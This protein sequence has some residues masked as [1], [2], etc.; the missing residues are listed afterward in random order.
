MTLLTLLRLRWRRWWRDGKTQLLLRLLWVSLLGAFVGGFVGWVG[1]VFPETLAQSGVQEAPTRVLSEHLLSVFAGLL[2][3]R[4]VLQRFVGFGWRPFLALPVERGFLCAMHLAAAGSLL[5]L[6]SLV[7]IAGLLASTIA[8]AT[9]AVGTAFWGVGTVLLVGATQFAHVILRVAWARRDWAV[10]LGAGGAAVGLIGADRAGVAVVRT[11]SAWLFGGLLD[12]G[13][14]PLLVIGAATGVLALRSTAALRRYTRSLT[15]GTGTTPARRWFHLDAWSWTH[16]SRLLLLQCIV[17]LRYRRGREL[18]LAGGALLVSGLGFL[19]VVDPGMLHT[20]AGAALLAT[21]AFFL[22]G[23]LPFG[24]GRFS[25]TWHSIHFDA[26]LARTS[27]SALLRAHFRMLLVLCGLSGLVVVLVAA[28][29]RPML[30]PSLC[31]F[32][33]YNAGVTCPLI[34]GVGVWWP[35]PPMDPTRSLSDQQFSVRQFATGGLLLSLLAGPLL[36]LLAGGAAV[37]L[38]GVAGAGILGLGTAPLWMPLVEGRLRRQ[39][40]ARAATARSI[41]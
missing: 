15:E 35:P 37:M 25:L 40:H 20:S 29:G 38:V 32:A 13:A 3:V 17:L 9:T 14:L 8:P 31:A 30:L 41:G 36:L 7:G 26:L 10:L 22:T 18:F 21:T 28:W 39:R 2:V 19:L 5:N 27:L 11:V 1:F 33:L 16:P 23:L 34:L 4:F 12:G 24:F 6:F